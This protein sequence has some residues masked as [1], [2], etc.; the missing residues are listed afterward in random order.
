M[1][2]LSAAPPVEP[3]ERPVGRRTLRLVD[4]GRADRVL[5]VDVW[6]PATIAGEPLTRYEPIPSIVFESASA[7]DEP[8]VRP[9]PAGLGRYPLILLSH[10]RTGM[11]FAYSLL[12]EALAARG[13]IVVASDHPGDA[14]NDWLSGT[15]VDDRTNETGRVGDFGFLLDTLL[16]GGTKS[17]P[18]LAVGMP[19]DLLAAIDPD[20]VVAIGHSYGAYTGL[21]AAAGVRGVA[22][23]VRLKAVVG[24]QP[25]TRSM[26]DAALSRVKVP[27]LLVIS[28]FDQTTPAA[29]DGDRPWQQLNGNPTWRMDLAG[30]AHH[31]SSDMGLY[32]ELATKIQGLPP[33]VTAY[34]AMMSGETTGSHIRPWRH[35]LL[36]QIR[37][38]AAFLDIVL[39]L[40]PAR[41]EAE[42]DRLAATDGVQLQ[43]R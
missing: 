21:A 41:G 31:A 36:L 11:R 3:P 26:S 37:A 38:I 1:T 23:D 6:Y 42:A 34:V 20:R 39:P 19:L 7:H 15:F 16:A 40:D 32:L 33:M 27:T 8:S 22:P 17:S 9:T 2:S 28:E 35:G 25:Y 43:R 4:P 14:L 30:A 13:F 18:D 12:S 10:G 29:T 24:I 5:L